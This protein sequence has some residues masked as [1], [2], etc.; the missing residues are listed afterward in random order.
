MSSLN[1]VRKQYIRAKFGLKVKRIGFW[2]P[3]YTLSNYG[4]VESDWRFTGINQDYGY[5]VANKLFWDLGE[6][7]DLLESANGVKQLEDK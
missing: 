1:K 6:L 3:Y 7:I 4:W 5:L 2:G